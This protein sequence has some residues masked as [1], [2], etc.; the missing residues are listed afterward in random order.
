MIIKTKQTR[1]R[2]LLP[3]SSAITLFPASRISFS[4]PELASSHFPAINSWL[5]Y[6]FISYIAF[7]FCIRSFKS[8]ILRV[9][10]VVFRQMLCSLFVPARFIT[11]MGIA[12]RKIP[13]PNQ[14]ET[15]A[16]TLSINPRESRA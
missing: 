1:L 5:P 14:K 12:T 2:S 8:P 13:A 16:Y 15:E 4:T 9:C 11:S 10:A 6:I 3:P 7:L